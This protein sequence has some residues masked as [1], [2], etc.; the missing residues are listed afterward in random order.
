MK[1]KL[2]AQERK[3][4]KSAKEWKARDKAVA[5]AKAEKQ[6]QRAYNI[7]NRQLPKNARVNP[8]TGEPLVQPRPGKEGG[9]DDDAGG[10]GGGRGGQKGGRGGK[11]ARPGFEG[12]ARGFLNKPAAGGRKGGK[13]K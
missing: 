8:V 7:A 9:G 3:K 1:K 4:A 5:K 2:K 10:G 6:T 11:Q 12:R 13:K